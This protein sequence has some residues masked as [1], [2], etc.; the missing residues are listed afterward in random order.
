MIET[1]GSS[2]PGKSYDWTSDERTSPDINTRETTRSPKFHVLGSMRATYLG[3]DILPR[4]RK[5][6]ALLGYLSL[7]SGTRIPRSRLAAMLWDRS[8]DAQARTSFRQALREVSL[9][10]GPLANEL[11]STRTATSSS[12]MPICAGSTRLPYW[13]PTGRHRAQAVAIWQRFAQASFSKGSTV[14]AYPLINGCWASEAALP[15]G[16]GKFSK[17]SFITSREQKRMRRSDPSSLAGSF[18]SIQRTRGRRGALMRALA[19][20]GERALAVREYTRCR[21][22]LRKALD[23]EPSPE[24]RA[25]S[26]A[27]RSFTGCEGDKAADPSTVSRRSGSSIHAPATNQGRPRVDPVLVMNVPQDSATRRKGPRTMPVL[28]L[29]TVNATPSPSQLIAQ[30]ER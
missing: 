19:D 29:A 21:K 17:R 9:A 1:I 30:A 18:R 6:R 15:R 23:I 2:D 13:Q 4:G 7:T 25:L 11:I 5:A 27:I 16:F 20:T 8:P 12:S 26:E 14:R 3:G 10:M 24:T 28:N 22:V